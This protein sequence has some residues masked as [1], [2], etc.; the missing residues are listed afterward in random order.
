MSRVFSTDDKAKCVIENVVKELGAAETP[1]EIEENGPIFSEFY[2]MF[3]KTIFVNMKDSKILSE[4]VENALKY[5]E[6]THPFS[7]YALDA[8]KLDWF[9]FYRIRT[10][11]KGTLR[12]LLSMASAR[13]RHRR[14]LRRELVGLNKFLGKVCER[15]EGSCGIVAGL[16]DFVASIFHALKIS[17]RTALYGRVNK[18]LLIRTILTHVNSTRQPNCWLPVSTF[19]GELFS[20]GDPD[21]VRVLTEEGVYRATLWAKSGF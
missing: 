21:T 20:S 6:P 13:L 10:W 4:A 18:T 16:S 8:F 12:N 3:F 2:A 11:S 7:T 1:E 17:D 19:I 9:K 5:V 14:P 15:A